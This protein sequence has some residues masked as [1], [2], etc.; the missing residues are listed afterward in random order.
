MS[1]PSS[2]ESALPEQE[3]SYLIIGAGAFGASTALHLI[4]THPNTS[5]TL[6]DR[7]AHTAPFRVAASWDWNKV[8]RADYSDPEYSKLGV[9]AQTLWRNDP[10]FREWY[11]ES[12]VVWIKSSAAA[13]GGTDMEGFVD[14]AVRNLRQLSDGKE[15]EGIELLSVED[16]K[17]AYGGFLRGADYTGVTKALVNKKS[18]WAEAKEAL[19]A[20]IQA[21]IDLGVE[22]R[23]AE[24]KRLGIDG[25]ACQ[26]VVIATA[27]G[28]AETTLKA[29]RVVLCTGAYTPK[30]LI[31]SAPRWEELHAKGRIVAMAVT[32]AVVPLG[33][34]G[35]NVL[36]RRPPVA[37]NDNP[38]ERGTL[39]ISISLACFEVGCLPLPGMNAFKCWGQII[40]RNTATDNALSTPP[41]RPDYAQWDVPQ[42]LRDDVGWALRSVFGESEATRPMEHYRICWD[43]VTPSEDFI[44]SPH[45]ACPGL[46]IATCGSFHGFKFLPVIG[47]YV[48]QMLEG[49]LDSALGDKWAWGRELPTVVSH[50]KLSNVELRDLN[51]E[52]LC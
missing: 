41:Q 45:S 42:V 16:A 34:E 6:V 48:V 4:R 44:I 14:K 20:T 11:H 19:H 37:I 2:S 47:K 1:I 8:I 46:Y 26:G 28:G 36:G 27:E 3:P 24:V 13:D 29:D 9:E 35:P 17:A 10:I 38:T 50:K 22:Y 7:D 5:I 33:E 30:L 51:K 15:A 52:K 49:Q 25:G 23:V 43:A 40:F 32:E 12:G 31:D 39:A 21:A 18:G